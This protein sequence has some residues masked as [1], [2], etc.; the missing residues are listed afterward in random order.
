MTGAQTI[1]LRDMLLSCLCQ[2]I[3]GNPNPPG[4]CCVRVG[5]AALALL[6]GGV[7]ICCEGLAYVSMQEV[8]PSGGSFPDADI[9]RQAQARCPPATWGVSFRMGI[10]RCA[11][12]TETCPDW[13][14]AADQDAHDSYALRRASCCFRNAVEASS[15]G[16]SVV[17]ERQHQNGPQGGCLERWQTIVV[18]MPN[19]DC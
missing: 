18:Q 4:I 7:D 3:S 11:P 12:D 13:T 1:A 6:P 2:A 10:V 16:M 14:A 5:E 15:I 8:Y 9:I 19:C 17:I